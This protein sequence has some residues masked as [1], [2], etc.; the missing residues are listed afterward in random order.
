MKLIKLLTIGFITY[1]LLG[2]AVAAESYAVGAVATHETQQSAL[3]DD[4]EFNSR[5]KDQTENGFESRFLHK[6]QYTGQFTCRGPAPNPPIGC[7]SGGCVCNQQG[8]NCRW[9]FRCR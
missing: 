6:A 1:F 7:V 9:T 5:V 4:R 3:H 2:T 8:Q